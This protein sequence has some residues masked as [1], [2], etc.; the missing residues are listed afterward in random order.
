MDSPSTRVR[1]AMAETRL[2]PH[3]FTKSAGERNLY[4]DRDFTAD[5]PLPQ[6]HL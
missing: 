6:Q 3:L 2:H 5:E 4:A 1:D